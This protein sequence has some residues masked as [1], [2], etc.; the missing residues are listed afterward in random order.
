MSGVSAR[1]RGWLA[2]V[3]LAPP[4]DA[5]YPQHIL[6]VDD[7]PSFLRYRHLEPNLVDLGSELACV[8]GFG[9]AEPSRSVE[10]RRLSATTLDHAIWRFQRGR[11]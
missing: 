6:E 1:G 4:E 8:A 7:L 11:K 3:L 5:S 10:L 2:R 9:V